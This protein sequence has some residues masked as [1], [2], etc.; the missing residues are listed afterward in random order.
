MT[1]HTNN[2]AQPIRWSIVAVIA[3]FTILGVLGPKLLWTLKGYQQTVWSWP[4]DAQYMIHPVMRM[5]LVAIG[6]II[7]LKMSK[8]TP[9]PTPRPSM[10]LAIGWPRATKGFLLGFVCT[11]PMLF[12][13]FICRTAS[14]SHYEV[15]YTAISPGLTEEIF[16]RAFMFGLLVQ[17]ARVPMWPAAII[18]AII[19]GLAH[20][21]ITPDAGQTILGQL[22]AWNAMIAVGGL[23]FAWLYVLSRWNLWLVIA[24]HIG[25]NLWWDMFDLTDTPFGA[26]GATLARIIPIGLAV[27]FVMG[28]SSQRTGDTSTIPA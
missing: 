11:L 9:R 27:M 3:L 1:E 2:H 5:V 22:N 13:G 8:G 6:T 23:M 20:I 10:G 19:F 21:D 16:Y 4:V 17:A 26:V 28:A 7:V 12:L 15:L 14:P 24:L 18:T 25:M